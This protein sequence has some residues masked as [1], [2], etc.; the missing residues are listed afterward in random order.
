MKNKHSLLLTGILTG[1]PWGTTKPLQ[2]YVY[3]KTRAGHGN[4]P[5][6]KHRRQQVRKWVQGTLT[7]TPAQQP[8]RGRFALG[9]SAWHALTPEQ[10]EVWR[11]PGEKIHLNCFQMFMRNWCLTT[12]LPTITLWDDGATIWLDSASQWDDGLTNFDNS[13]TFWDGQ[14]VTT[15]DI[16]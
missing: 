14:T 13:G 7:N 9:V 3:Q 10:K 2:K 5:D 16:L 4:I 1:I 8:Q 15:W 6:D 12:P 11:V